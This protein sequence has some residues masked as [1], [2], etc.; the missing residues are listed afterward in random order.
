MLSDFPALSSAWLVAI[1]FIATIIGLIRFQRHP[2]SVFGCTMLFLYSTRLVT[3]D[4]V[5]NSFSNKGL[6]TLILLMVCSIA[7]EKTRLLRVIA[8]KVIKPSYAGTL[9]RLFGV[10]VTSS[11]ILNNTAVVSTLLAP[12][13][14]NPYHAASK[15]LMPLSYAAILGGTLTL[16]GT[17]T[18][19]IVNSLVISYDLPPLKFFDFTLIGVSVVSLCGLMLWLLTPLLPVRKISQEES[20]EYFIDA[21]V[22]E[23]SSL[24]G[25]SVEE[26]GLRHLESLFLVEIVRS[27]RLISPVS[28][29]EVIMPDDQLVFSGDVHKVLQLSQ[30]DGLNLF[31]HKNGILTSNLTEVVIRP[32]STLIGTSLKHAGFRALFDAA[33]VAIRRDG[34]KVSGK[35]GDVQLQPGDFLVLAV[36]EDFRNRNNV[37]KNFVIISGVEPDT[38][39]KG[40]YEWLAIG[41]FFTAVLLAAL[42][43]VSLFN[44][45]FVLLSILLLTKCLTANEVMRRLPVD[46]WLIISSALLLSKAL[47]SSGALTA[48]DHIVEQHLQDSNPIWALAAVYILTWLLTEL[49]T[50]NAAAALMF[51]IGL[52]I[53]TSLGVDYMPF[54]LI[55]AFGASASFISPYGYQTNLMVYNAGNYRLIDFVR[56]G[57]PISV[58]YGLAAII[59]ISLIYGII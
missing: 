20:K 38:H 1:V 54:I 32:E 14:N 12:I 15:L 17:S 2:A 57:A 3:T 36:G 34:E 13:K 7:L 29:T 4:Q 51:P 40:A 30:F 35:L 47:E 50:N 41:G 45:M 42:G 9:A 44:A 11:A 10:T 19:L 22:S 52:G 39:L 28:P 49:V 16:I 27:H 58:C 33:V 31:A 43:V 37:S 48:L 55:V 46:I 23:G 18:N 24:I 6:I 25:R 8:T 59:S 56:I 5:I 53:A 21:T 26:N